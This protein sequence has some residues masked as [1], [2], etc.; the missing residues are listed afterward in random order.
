MTMTP[1]HKSCTY[2]DPVIWGLF[3]DQVV[4]CDNELTL[5]VSFEYFVENEAKHTYGD[6]Y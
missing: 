2:P 5:W 3:A 4:I 6:K 1:A